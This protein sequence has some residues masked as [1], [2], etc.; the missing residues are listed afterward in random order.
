MISKTHLSLLLL[1]LSMHSPRTDAQNISRPIDHYTGEMIRDGQTI[2]ISVDFPMPSAVPNKPLYACPMHPRVISSTPGKCPICRMPLVLLSTGS[3]P[4][5]DLHVSL[6][7]SYG[8]SLR[9]IDYQGGE[10]PSCSWPGSI[11]V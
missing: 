6:P 10:S 11:H 3:A 8:L 1:L 7:S 9:L 5:A 4:R 2:K